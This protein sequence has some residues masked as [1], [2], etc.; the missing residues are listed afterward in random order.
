[1][2][3]NGQL[4]LSAIEDSKFTIKL[5]KRLAKLT[6]DNIE[7]KKTKISESYY[8]QNE[9]KVRMIAHEILL[10]PKIRPKSIPL[11]A[12]LTKFFIE[13]GEQNSNFK[14]FRD[15]IKAEAFHP[16]L[17]WRDKVSQMRFFRILFK[18]NL[19]SI[20]EIIK[21]ITNFPL[22]QEDTY[23]I[24]F[25][26]FAPE[27]YEKKNERF[28]EILQTTYNFT[29]L[30][31]CLKAIRN[32]FE[33]YADAEDG[34]SKH[35][36]ILENGWEKGTLGYALI[37]DDVSFLEGLLPKEEEEEEEKK[38][39]PRI[40]M[41]K[42]SIWDIIQEQNAEEE[43][44]YDWNQ[45]LEKNPL[46]SFP[47]GQTKPTI[48]QMAVL[49]G[50]DKCFKFLLKQEHLKIDEDIVPYVCAG[51]K[52]LILRELEKHNIVFEKGLN[53]SVEYRWDTIFEWINHSK[54]VQYEWVKKEAFLVAV[55]TNN[56]KQILYYIQKG[57][58]SVSRDDLWR[59]PVHTASMH[60]HMTGLK[61]LGGSVKVDVNA[62][63]DKKMTPMHF[64]A[65]NAYL[66]VMKYLVLK[67]ADCAL[68]D[69]ASWT[70]LHYA[71]Q[72]G[73][74]KCCTFLMAQSGVN[75]NALSETNWTPVHVAASEGRLNI[76]DI[77]YK[78][79]ADVFSGD[80]FG[81]TPLH[82]AAKYGHLNVVKF[83]LSVLADPNKLTKQGQT[84]LDLAA[85]KEIADYLRANGARESRKRG[86]K[87]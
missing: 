63:D 58:D 50:A 73:N 51:G 20:E 31:K 67:G 70:P 28:K 6:V 85:T 45:Q 17:D 40:E 26:F 9:E 13:F 4:L 68:R 27:I 1:M 7:K 78:M 46:E 8:S 42:K 33:G 87:I 80:K 44:G 64:A 55:E 19:Y 59:T 2:K 66:D 30:K 79:R 48:L 15:T 29:R 21:E 76:I 23:F 11:L 65:Q 83:L 32:K 49:Y 34:W 43:D 47:M 61:L 60:G 37:N 22:Q 77:M 5:Q 86:S 84:V 16:V 3:K 14:H 36:E 69:I 53:K 35:I 24:L 81:M 25:C 18:L 54:E 75:I 82:I 38:E 39:S 41:K 71:V 56:V 12:D 72:L 52:M 57:V 10:I 62:V 74:E